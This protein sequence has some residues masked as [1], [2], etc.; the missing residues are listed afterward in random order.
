MRTVVCGPNHKGLQCTEQDWLRKVVESI[1]R[2]RILPLR[3]GIRSPTK[4]WHVP[5]DAFGSSCPALSRKQDS[6]SR[7]N[8]RM[9]EPYL[10]TPL[11]PSV[12][13]R[14][15]R[16]QLVRSAS[17]NMAIYGR[18]WPSN[19]TSKHSSQIEKDYPMATGSTIS[20]RL[21]IQSPTL[22]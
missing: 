1:C 2:K 20:H 5:P 16:A 22:P 14:A 3:E 7:L 19:A 8:C 11:L 13:K 6:G 18:I 12:R 21:S 9:S 17:R 4:I 10:F 15:E